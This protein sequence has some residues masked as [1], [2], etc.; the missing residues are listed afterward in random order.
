MI[1]RVS[2]D[3][4]ERRRIWRTEIKIALVLKVHNYAPTSIIT[5]QKLA[6][7]SAM[8]GVSRSV[9]RGRRTGQVPE[10]M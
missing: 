3:L 6:L 1:N 9:N 2:L 8:P 10:A 7:L 4:H 5:Q